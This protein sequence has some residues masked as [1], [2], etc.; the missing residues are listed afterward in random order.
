MTLGSEP[1]PASIRASIAWAIAGSASRAR[2]AAMTSSSEREAWLVIIAEAARLFVEDAFDRGQARQDRQHLVGL[3]LILRD[4]EPRAGEL[5]HDGDLFGD[6]VGVE[7]HRYGAEHLR[8]GDRPIELRSVR[9]RERHAVA[10]GDPEI[11]ETLGERARLLIGVRPGPGPPDAMFLEPERRPLAAH[12][13]VDAHEFGEGVVRIRACPRAPHA[14][15]PGR[16]RENIRPRRP[17]K[18]LR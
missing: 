12:P 7:R 2:P 5:Q 9:A 6:R 16:R 13:G 8:G 14:V 10:S 15:S 1:R 17:C 3:L 11:G 18:A 4:D